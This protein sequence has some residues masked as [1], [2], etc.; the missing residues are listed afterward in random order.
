MSVIVWP[1]H[2]ERVERKGYETGVQGVPSEAC[3]YTPGVFG[4]S[5][6]DTWLRG[7]QRGYIEHKA[8]TK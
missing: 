6:R 5:D 1:S 4:S 3:P 2:I 8:I 7:W